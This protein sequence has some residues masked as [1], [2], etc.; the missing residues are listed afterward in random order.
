MHKEAS[1]GVEVYRAG[2]GDRLP[3]LSTEY[4]PAAWSC[5]EEAKHFLECVRTGAPFRSSAEDTLYDVKLCEDI[6]RAFLG[7]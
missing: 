5:R 3:T 6:Y 1:A 2:D 4:A 7:V